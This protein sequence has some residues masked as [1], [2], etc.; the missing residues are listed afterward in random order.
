VPSRNSGIGL[1]G[2]VGYRWSFLEPVFSVDWFHGR[3]EDRDL[4]VVKGG[5]NFWIRNAAVNVKTEF[6]A[7]KTGDL[8][9]APWIKCFTTQAQL[10]F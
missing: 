10:F 7:Q 5:L 4:L 1:L 3:Q 2:E 9:S 8:A 6:G